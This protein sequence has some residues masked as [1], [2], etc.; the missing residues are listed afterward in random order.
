MLK[1]PSSTAV[2]SCEVRLAAVRPCWLVLTVY[3]TSTDEEEE[4]EEEV[5]DD[6]EDERVIDEK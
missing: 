1:S 5:V 6:R 4:E 3:V 2:V